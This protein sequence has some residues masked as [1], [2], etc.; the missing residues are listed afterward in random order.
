MTSDG[1]KYVVIFH[2][3]QKLSETKECTHGH[4]ALTLFSLPLVYSFTCNLTT[5]CQLQH[6]LYN[7]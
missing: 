3:I 2:I 4:N 6:M 5:L 1:V 7:D